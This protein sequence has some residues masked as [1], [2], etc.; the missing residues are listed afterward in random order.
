MPSV[1]SFSEA[2]N[3]SWAH[4]LLM[5][6]RAKPVRSVAA[7]WVGKAK[8]EPQRHRFL[9]SLT[10]ECPGRLAIPRAFLPLP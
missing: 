9:P 10:I 5:N 8:I 1:S 6:L 3:T 7:N 2:K 4:S